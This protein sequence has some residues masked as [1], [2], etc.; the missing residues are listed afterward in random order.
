MRENWE[1]IVS[2]ALSQ[3]RTKCKW[4][5]GVSKPLNLQSLPF[6][7]SKMAVQCTS[8]GQPMGPRT[9]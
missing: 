6:C 8:I 1:D 4:G 7:R 2:F 3:S 5:I 9:I